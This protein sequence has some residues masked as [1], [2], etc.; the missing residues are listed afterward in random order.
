MSQRKDGSTAARNGSRSAE[1]E[2]TTRPSLR[3]GPNGLHGD[4]AGSSSDGMSD[5]VASAGYFARGFCQLRYRNT[6]LE[7]AFLQFTHA[8]PFARMVLTVPLLCCRVI[9]SGLR[10]KDGLSDL[11]NV[12]TSTIIHGTL[13]LVAL[14][15]FLFTLESVVRCMPRCVARRITSWRRAQLSEYLVTFVAA[16]VRAADFTFDR[17]ELQVFNSP[18]ESLHFSMLN[19]R[20]GSLLLYMA[21]VPPRLVTLIP[22]ALALLIAN[23]AILA[24]KHPSG[25][26]DICG[27]TIVPLELILTSLLIRCW[28]Q[29][30]RENFEASL[31]LSFQAERGA[32][33]VQALASEL[34]TCLAMAS[35]ASL[36]TL[37]VAPSE[38]PPP[39][40][41]AA[42]A[43]AADATDSREST[44]SMDLDVG[45]GP[46]AASTPVVSRSA[47]IRSDGTV[48]GPS[49]VSSPP[50]DSDAADERNTANIRGHLCAVL[51]I[52]SVGLNARTKKDLAH[53]IDVTLFAASSIVDGQRFASSGD[54]ACVLF[55]ICGEAVA[56]MAAV[57]AVSRTI[58]RHFSS[59]VEQNLAVAVGDS[60]LQ[61]GID[62]ENVQVAREPHHE[63]FVVGDAIACAEGLSELALPGS[64]LVSDRAWQPAS[65]SYTLTQMHNATLNRHRL[66]LFLLGMPW[67]ERA[68]RSEAR[69]RMDAHRELA[70]MRDH[71]A[72]TVDVNQFDASSSR[73]DSPPP[74]RLDISESSPE[75]DLR[76][77]LS[78]SLPTFPVMV[79]PPAPSSHETQRSTPRSHPMS[80]IDQLL[81]PIA[82]QRSQQPQ[83]QQRQQQPQQQNASPFSHAFLEL[84]A[85]DAQPIDFHYHWLWGWLFVAAD[86]EN[87]FRAQEC[88]GKARLV[89]ALA[90]L[91]VCIDALI[92]FIAG[93]MEYM[94]WQS[95][96]MWLGAFLSV[97]GLLIIVQ[98]RTTLGQKHMVA[99]LVVD[100][101]MILGLSATLYFHGD[102]Y[103]PMR[104]YLVD[105]ITLFL[106]A[107]LPWVPSC[108]PVVLLSVSNVF[109]L[110]FS[111]AR[112]TFSWKDAWLPV[113]MVITSSLL[114]QTLR[115]RNRLLYADRLAAFRSAER[116][117]GAR[118]RL[119]REFEKV[120]PAAVAGR[121][122]E[123]G[124][125]CTE[126]STHVECSGT[127]DVAVV[128]AV[129]LGGGTLRAACDPLTR[130]RGLELHAAVARTATLEAAGP[131]LEVW[132]ET[133]L[134]HTHAVPAAAVGFEHVRV[135]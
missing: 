60:A 109:L 7:N 78:I 17:V 119:R 123:E 45:G 12:E 114:V 57:C 8:S 35:D 111:S 50:R 74:Q 58:R 67:E 24:S 61:M 90:A 87:D 25:P 19:Q 53:L 134:R 63:P 94:T 56:Q 92:W 22:A 101:L 76:P 36:N 26:V 55:D 72:F 79:A 80:S 99:L 44:V 121:L 64:T 93:G 27:T 82:S 73:H 62:F 31:R 133:V 43:Y 129:H 75:T 135:K 117:A 100:R 128:A 98:L 112:T 48:G 96:V 108:V 86:V 41:S 37:A 83:Q 89:P 40:S 46:L 5:D 33:L 52:R 9:I 106:G 105:L 71:A 118:D 88:R 1:Q 28:E 85:A 104:I 29:S 68:T 23:T 15:A 38:T 122:V 69:I 18:Y 81:P 20:S 3:E 120:V 2:M 66:G 39:G 102:P 115:Y 54:V 34:R 11:R 10:G 131:D 30:R 70:A 125:R 107:N 103:T 132:R 14:I 16:A 95:W 4:A 65:A 21:F 77:A 130:V 49:Q 113:G 32:L 84:V 124:S 126:G 97:L 51:V 59:M 127:D 110:G 116:W 47:R 6:Q 42:T 13:A 91:L